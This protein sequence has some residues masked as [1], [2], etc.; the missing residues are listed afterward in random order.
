MLSLVAAP[1]TSIS[2]LV[3]QIRAVEVPGT[4][5]VISP[6]VE[7]RLYVFFE[8]A[9]FLFGLRRQLLHCLVAEIIDR[10]LHDIKMISHVVIPL[11][12]VDDLHV[13]R[14]RDPVVVVENVQPVAAGGHVLQRQRAGRERLDSLVDRIHAGHRP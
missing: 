5:S 1:L 11:L 4:P 3:D 10:N 12:S 8:R 13:D 2:H 14:L 6:R 7:N 9:V